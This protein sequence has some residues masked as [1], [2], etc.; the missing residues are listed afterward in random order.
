MNVVVVDGGC[1]VTIYFRHVYLF[2]SSRMTSPFHF[3]V[4]MPL[5]SLSHLNWRYLMYSIFMCSHGLFFYAPFLPFDHFDV[6][7]F[8]FFFIYICRICIVYF[9]TVHLYKDFAGF[10]VVKCFKIERRA[11]KNSKHLS[12]HAFAE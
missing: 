5:S 2:L 8:R 3:N 7:T 9:T 1:V 10:V 12:I 4:S 11:K 6:Q